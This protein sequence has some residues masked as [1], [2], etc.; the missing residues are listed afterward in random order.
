MV[1]CFLFFFH[2]KKN[3]LTKQRLRHALFYPPVQIPVFQG[4]NKPI[5]GNSINAGYFHGKD[6]LGDSPDPKAPSLDMI[7]KEHGVDA[8]IRIVNEHPGEVGSLSTVFW[9]RSCF[10]ISLQAFTPQISLVATAPLT[11]L[12]LAVKMDPSLPSKLRGLYIMGGNTEC[13]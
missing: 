8:I 4:A 3:H 10:S 5:M 6:G 7:Q 11:N 1:F 13:Q 2:W 9:F 12:A